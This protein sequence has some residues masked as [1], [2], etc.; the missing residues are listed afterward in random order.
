MSYRTMRKLNKEQ[1][2]EIRK[3]RNEKNTYELSKLFKVSQPTIFYWTNN[4]TKEKVL[5]RTKKW[6]KELHKEKRSKIYKSRKEYLRN[7]M[8]NRYQTD[9]VYRLKQIE[10]VKRRK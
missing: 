9:E 3:L 4:K 10:R 6:F 5:T 2:E 1:I 8:R 7:Y